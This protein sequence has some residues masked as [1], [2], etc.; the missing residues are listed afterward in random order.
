MNATQPV[1]DY[2][3][4]GAGPA[5]SVLASRLSE[6]PGVNV[7]LIEAGRDLKP[8]QE[9]AS[10]SDAAFRA[11]FDPA[12][13]TPYFPV[14]AR[15]RLS[16]MGPRMIAYRQPWVL[17][18]GSSVNAMHAQRGLPEDYDE[19]RQLGIEGWDWDEVLP[20][21][22]RC[23]TDL[24]FQDALHG[25]AGPLSISRIN[26]SEWSEFSRAARNA[27]RRCGVPECKDLN[28][29]MGDC[30]GPVPLNI[31][32]NQR[33]SAPVAYLDSSV[34]SRPNLAILCEAEV[35]RLIV[36]S[37]SVSGVEIEQASQVLQYRARETIVSAGALRSPALL[38]RSGIGPVEG[39][40]SCGIGVVVDRPGVGAAL[41][42][43]VHMSLVVHLRR[44]ARQSPEMRAP[45]AIVVRYSSDQAGC[46]HTDM[47]LNIWEK[48]PG[49]LK[50]D[51]LS[52]QMAVLMVLVNKTYSRGNVKLD[53][54]DPFGAPLINFNILDDPRDLDRIVHGLGMVA[55]ILADSEV[56]ALTNLAFVP[57]PGRLM[58]WL[59]Q[60]NARASI[61]SF[62]GALALDTSGPLRK[63]LLQQE[64]RSLKD[65]LKDPETSRRAVLDFAQPA[66]H[67]T[68]TCAMG[69]SDSREAVV[70]SRCRVIGVNRLRVVDGSIFPTPL[71]AGTH[72]PIIMAAEKAAEMI[73][74]DRQV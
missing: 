56:A 66:S 71:R 52:R 19:W 68:G 44:G 11:H 21:F 60:Y 15:D 45:C 72:L 37:G 1:F 33:I 40:R 63:F 3:V 67:A 47:V 69:K 50:S 5:G 53:P 54:K 49:S 64:G 8:G 28:G 6:N 30:V 36:E 51:P 57:T 26:E 27:L 13:F 59:T 25:A 41:H 65:V 43:H 12:F 14:V 58:K 22:R 29:L 70:D 55:R 62:V 18:G 7:L 2:I 4:I 34:R 73:V 38:M 9:P 20:Y 23:E 24:D 17:G 61:V 31:R 48:A 32:G 16:R 46:P 42:N 39:L 74:E 10:I 35:K